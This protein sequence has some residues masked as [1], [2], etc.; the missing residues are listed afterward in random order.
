VF[1]FGE[2]LQ[3]EKN[4][5][6]DENF[7]C[8]VIYGTRP[9]FIKMIMLINELKENKSICSLKII[10]TGQHK[11]LLKPLEI[12]YN[13]KP[14]F[15]LN[16]MSNEQSLAS[17]LIRIQQQIL[18]VYENIKPK[19][20][21][22]QGDTTTAM[23][24]SIVA[25]HAGIHVFHIESG[26]R[27]G[28]LS[29]PF[30]EEFNR[31]AI[32]LVCSV[33]FSPSTIAEKE[34]LAEGLE[35]SRIRNIGNT[36]IDTLNYSLKNPPKSVLE[37][38]FVYLKSIISEEKDRKII[39]NKTTRQLLD[40]G[41][42]IVLI[43]VH[44][45]ENLMS[46]AFERIG[47]SILKLANN[48]PSVIFIAPLH[49]NPE[50]RKTFIP[51]W[52]NVKNIYVVEP[53]LYPFF[54]QVL[55]RI[56]LVLTDSGGI[57]EEGIALHLPVLI[58]R[59]NTERIEGILCGASKLIGETVEKIYE[60]TKEILQNKTK[61]SSMLN[62]CNPYGDGKATE[63]I[64]KTVLDF[65][66]NKK[67]VIPSKLLQFRAIVGSSGRRVL[68][69]I[70]NGKN[71]YQSIHNSKLGS[72]YNEVD[73]VGHWWIWKTEWTHLMWSLPSYNIWT[74]E[75]IEISA[76]LKILLGIKSITLNF[77]SK[78]YDPEI[79]HESA[80]LH[81][82]KNVS[83]YLVPGTLN[84]RISIVQYWISQGWNPIFRNKS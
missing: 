55:N 7:I 34:L 9:E 43:T 25:F 56:S 15:D 13:V 71:D 62:S 61:Y 74:G 6:N 65:K 41:K 20:I 52:K 51:M 45:R 46:G 73:F 11:Q 72:G 64:L 80:G 48:F 30:P 21:F 63:R 5:S 23:A 60:S 22:V 59:T 37:N 67:D 38:K 33:C 4:K 70:V 18:L 82:L 14:D 42:H 57:Q 49:Y 17:L 53:P 40:T 83:S 24:S 84:E 27:T 29:S 35:T 8:L 32:A 76:K 1:K 19:L 26:L 54:V 58:M 44:R 50:V 36:V 68:P 81:T 3:L 12:Y 10:S 28:D 69:S 66:K 77:P 75:D 78:I 39:L 79:P 2:N 31:K 16:I 47:R